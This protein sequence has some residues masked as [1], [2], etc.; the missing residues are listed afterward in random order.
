MYLRFFAT[1]VDPSDLDAVQR[2]FTEDIKPAFEG[3]AGCTWLEL[4]VSTEKSAGGLLDGAVL[5]H[6]TSLDELNAALES[7]TVAESMVRILPFLQIEPVTKT[8]E[9]LR[10]TR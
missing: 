3:M 1:A 9:I 8:F 2:I 6:W 7:R 4:V 10:G 5:S